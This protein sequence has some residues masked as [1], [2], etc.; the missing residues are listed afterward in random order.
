MDDVTRTIKYQGLCARPLFLVAASRVL[1]LCARLHFPNPNP[2]NVRF[3]LI[4]KPALGV[5]V[6][7]PWICMH[8]VARFLAATT[9]TTVVVVV[10][11]VYKRIIVRWHSQRHMIGSELMSP[12]SAIDYVHCIAGNVRQRLQHQQQR[13]RLIVI[14]A[15]VHV[16]DEWVNPH[17]NARTTANRQAKICAAVYSRKYLPVLIV[18]SV[19]GG[20]SG[21]RLDASAR[22]SVDHERIACLHQERGTV[23]VTDDSDRHHNRMYLLALFS[24]WEDFYWNCIEERFCFDESIGKG[25]R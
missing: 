15:C 24:I 21:R 11:A 9:T 7:V 8:W 6:R 20:G 2:K 1:L 12:G 14:I 18:G 23:E 17:L 10:F 4:Y 22:W 5:G 3:P 19:G 16:L 25:I 13:R